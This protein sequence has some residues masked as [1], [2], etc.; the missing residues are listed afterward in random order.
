MH[1]KAELFEL[2]QRVK[3]CNELRDGV[4]KINEDRILELQA[5]LKEMENILI[6]YQNNIWI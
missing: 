4:N 6:I 5:K 1:S 2:Q 3:I